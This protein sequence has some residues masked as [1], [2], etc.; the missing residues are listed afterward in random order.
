MTTRRSGR[1]GI[2][3]ATPMAPTSTARLSTVGAR[4]VA[5]GNE[6]RA[7]DLLADPDA[8]DREASSPRNR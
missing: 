8:E 2:A 5:V 7:A 3:E 6:R 1:Q 4:V